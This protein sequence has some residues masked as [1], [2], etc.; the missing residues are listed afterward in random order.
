M[1]QPSSSFYELIFIFRILSSSYDGKEKQDLGME[2]SAYDEELIQENYMGLLPLSNCPPTF[3][4]L[5]H[6]LYPS[7]VGSLDIHPLLPLGPYSMPV[8]LQ[9]CN[10]R[11]ILSFLGAAHSFALHSTVT[12]I[13]ATGWRKGSLHLF[14]QAPALVF[15]MV[16]NCWEGL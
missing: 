9:H 3:P 10:I 1:Q 16:W 14:C 2:V 4:L 13:L 6:V 11:N 15:N 5:L 7:A 12:V 8:A